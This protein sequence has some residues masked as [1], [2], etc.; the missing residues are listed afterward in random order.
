MA[1]IDHLESCANSLFFYGMKTLGIALGYGI[2]IL[3]GL[4]VYAYFKVVAFLLPSRLGMPFGLVWVSLGL[5][6]LFNTLFNHFFAMIIKPTSP[7]D[8][9]RIE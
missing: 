4:Q 7:S 9:I 1:V 3:I 6:I 5:I 2:Y 8:L